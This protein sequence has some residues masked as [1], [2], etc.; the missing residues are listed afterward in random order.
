MRIVSMKKEAL[1]NLIKSYNETNYNW[2]IVNE[3]AL[4]AELIQAAES[5][6]DYIEYY[7]ATLRV[8]NILSFNY[9]K[10]FNF[11]KSEDEQHGTK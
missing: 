4:E 5:D 10:D 2:P 9:P 11:I 6:K 3:S 8:T 1:S 7:N